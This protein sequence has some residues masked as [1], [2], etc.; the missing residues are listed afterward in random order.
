[1][2]QVAPLP[3][4]VGQQELAS[5]GILVDLDRNKKNETADHGLADFSEHNG[6]DF[7][8]KDGK[9]SIGEARD[10]IKKS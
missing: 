1:M 2:A 5:L 6:T 10:A 9:F 8:W 7:S 3:P 4:A